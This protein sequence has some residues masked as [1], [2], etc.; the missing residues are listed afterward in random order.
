MKGLERLPDHLWADLV[1][2]PFEIRGRGPHSYD[3]FGVLCEVYRRHG[4]IIPDLYYGAD[5]Q[6]QAELLL[7]GSSAW[8]RTEPQAGAG[9]LFRSW[10]SLAPSHVGVLIDQD[11]FIH[12]TEDFG[13]VALGYLSRMNKSLVLG[14]FLPPDELIQRD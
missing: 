6:K 3:C 11:Q 10:S 5:P 8:T 9:L 13:Q 7:R 2:L 1:G 12:A 14:C 4:I